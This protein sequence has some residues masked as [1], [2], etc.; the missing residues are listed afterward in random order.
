MTFV[1]DPKL[2]KIAEAY[3]LDAVDFARKQFGVTLDFTDDSIR[4]VETI[5]DRFHSD[6]KRDHP[7]DEQ[8]SKFAQM[9]GSYIGEVFRRNHGASWGKVTMDGA[10][11]PGMSSTRGLLLWPWTRTF[12]RIVKGPEDNM[13]HYYQKL[14]ELSDHRPGEPRP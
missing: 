1:P 12:N 11:V 4:R 7:T 2:D 13:W 5:L 10:T 14:L 8:I 3:A 9:L 6:F